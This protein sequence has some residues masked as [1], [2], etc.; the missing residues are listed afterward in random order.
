M[1]GDLIPSTADAA[2]RQLGRDI[3]DG[4]QQ[5]L[6]SAL[7]NLQLAEQCFDRDPDRAR[8]LLGEARGYVQHGLDDLRVLTAGLYQAMLAK[9]ELPTAVSAL[10]Q[11][12]A[13]PAAKPAT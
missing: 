10:A 2:R 9:Y 6:V 13:R 4:P 7:I 1:Y 11:T 12:S 3:H 8:R 5:R